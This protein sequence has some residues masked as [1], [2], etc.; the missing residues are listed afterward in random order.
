MPD[1]PETETLDTIISP[2]NQPTV[3]VGTPKGRNKQEREID[4]RRLETEAFWKQVFAT[5][6]GR[7]EMWKIMGE[8][9]GAFKSEFAAAPGGVPDRD[10]TW[11]RRG[12]HDYGFGLYLQLQMIV[13]EGLRLMLEENDPR[14]KKP[15]TKSRTKN[16]DR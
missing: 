6:V 9:L 4:L 16:P 7:R 11:H 15:E 8:G 2:S 13:P 14:F 5:I 1:E 10:A 12:Q 3:D